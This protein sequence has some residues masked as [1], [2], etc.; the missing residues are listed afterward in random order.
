MKWITNPVAQL[1]GTVAEFGIDHRQV[2]TTSF[3]TFF[4]AASMLCSMVRWNRPDSDL[5]AML[6]IPQRV[7]TALI[8]GIMA[9]KCIMELIE[10]HQMVE[11]AGYAS[12]NPWALVGAYV[13]FG[14]LV[15][16]GVLLLGEVRTRGELRPGGTL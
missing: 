4:I 9:V 5:A 7:I 15:P 11:T 10:N 8:A 1:I 6:T 2:I 12:T 14:L 16:I 3:A 13:L